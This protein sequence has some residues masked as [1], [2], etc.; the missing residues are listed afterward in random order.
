MDFRSLLN[1]ILRTQ[2]DI[3]P[4]LEL[5]TTQIWGL[6]PDRNINPITSNPSRYFSQSD[7][8]GII[9]KILVRTGCDN[10]G[11]ILE[12]G[13]G[14]GTENNSL[15][16]VARGWKSYWIGAEDLSFRFP[17]SDKHHFRK[18]WVTLKNVVSLTNEA[19]AKL[20]TTGSSIDC[21]SIDLDGNDYH[22]V[23]K[24]LNNSIYPSLWICEYSAKFPPGVKWIMPYDEKH[25]WQSDDY[26]GASFTAFVELFSRHGYFP[27]A[28]SVQGANV[29]FVRDDY[30]SLFADVARAEE[31]IYQ[32]PLY[33]L[34]PKWGHPISS[35][36]IESLFQSSKEL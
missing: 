17:V 18:T 5:Q 30:K 35:K 7:E 3:S 32:P 4:I 10:P 23:N 6:W 16:L 9:E 36:T 25:T 24:L 12:F 8:D 15:A 26:F 14:D 1:R 27:V 2:L 20:G 31:R 11:K 22:F 21:V 29:F 28:C 34:V 19:L 13:V 33:N